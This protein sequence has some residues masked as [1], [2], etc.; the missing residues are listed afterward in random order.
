MKVH[1]LQGMKGQNVLALQ[2]KWWKGKS[3]YSLSRTQGL[4]HVPY[5]QYTLPLLLQELFWWQ[6]HAAGKGAGSAKGQE[7]DLSCA[8]FSP[9]H[10]S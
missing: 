5:D 10:P 3:P 8:L 1:D 9:V 2:V 6:P 7:L 4:F